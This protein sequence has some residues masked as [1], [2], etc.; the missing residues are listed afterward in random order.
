MNKAKMISICGKIPI[1]GTSLRKIARQ[2]PEGS[3]VTIKNGPLA[4]SQWQRSHRYVSAYWLGIYELPIQECLVRELRPGHVFYDIGANG[5]FFS[6]LGSR[7]VGP[8][9]KVYAFEPLPENI[10]SIEAQLRLNQVSN[11]TVVDAA[12]AD[13]GGSVEF[14]EGQDTSTAHLKGNHSGDAG[15]AAIRVRSVTLDEFVA[16]APSPHFIKMDIEGAELAALR[17]A[18]RLLSSE[19]PPGLL[20]EFHGEAL[21]RDGRAMLE[22]FGYRFHSLDGNML[23]HRSDERHILCIPRQADSLGK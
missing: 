2:Y 18:G 5:G 17:G 9:G 16:T 7:C 10:R 8:E 14:C 11:C 19:N 20:I 21:R 15:T 13:C 3:V 12:V 23:D 4:G 6:L 1:L 22:K